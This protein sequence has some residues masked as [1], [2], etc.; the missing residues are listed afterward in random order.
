[1]KLK[2]LAVAGSFSKWVRSREHR[3]RK[4]EC[5]AS[6]EEIRTPRS[7]VFIIFSVLIWEKCDTWKDRQRERE[8]KAQF[9]T[10]YSAKPHW[11][12]LEYTS[13]HLF[14][15]ISSS[16]L[17][18]QSTKIKPRDR[19]IWQA[20]QKF[21]QISLFAGI[22][23]RSV[24]A[25]RVAFKLLSPKSYIDSSIARRADPSRTFTFPDVVRIEWRP[26]CDNVYD[27]RFSRA[28]ADKLGANKFRS[29]QKVGAATKFYEGCN[30]IVAAQTWRE[31][32]MY[33]KVWRDVTRTHRKNGIWERE[34]NERE[35]ER[36]REGERR[37]NKMHTRRGKLTGAGIVLRQ[38]S[39]L[40]AW[41]KSPD[42][43]GHFGLLC[44]SKRHERLTRNSSSLFNLPAAKNTAT[45]NEETWST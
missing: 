33:R 29:S 20:N 36:E 18:E 5:R 30:D 40:Y 8:R 12:S 15:F 1:V 34:T 16:E 38:P 7:S 39:D 10:A 42:N 24:N 6:N 45:R 41:K 43:H 21:I 44:K 22:P 35:R 23:F 17:R 13:A 25:C 3:A 19:P 11:R 9:E 2:S 26:I 4:S 28:D 14:L 32:E 37:R 31:R 27:C